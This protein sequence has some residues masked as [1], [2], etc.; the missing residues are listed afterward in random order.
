[1]DKPGLKQEHNGRWLD[2]RRWKSLPGEGGV[3]QSPG[4]NGD[5]RNDNDNVTMTRWH[6]DNDN[7]NDNVAEERGNSPTP[8][9]P[10]DHDDYSR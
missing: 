8:R 10:N 6:D 5:D 1:M 7:D 3:H 9:F 2:P 4:V